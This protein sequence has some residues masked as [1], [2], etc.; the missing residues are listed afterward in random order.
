MDWGLV[1][2]VKAPPEKVGAFVAHH[3]ALGCARIWLYFDDPEDPA[4]DALARIPQVTTVRC[5]DIRWA[6][7]GNRPDRHQNR[8]VKN[9]QAAW[10]ACRL[11]WLGHIDVDEFLHPAQ[12]IAQILASLPPDQLTLRMEPFE[13]MHDPSLPDDIFTARLFRGPLK[14]RFAHL[15]TPVLGAYA[16]ILPEG[17]LSHTNGKSFF[18]TGIPGLSPRLHGAFLNKERLPG[19]PFDRR[20]PLLHFHAQD[21]EAWLKALPFRRSRGAYQ[22]HP[23]LQAHLQTAGPEEIAFFYDRTQRLTAD[24]A[25]LLRGE[26]RLIETDLSLRHKLA[27]LAR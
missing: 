5:D 22:Y 14:P 2:T 9:A 23:E 16:P 8:Q 13:A 25:T 10:R 27:Q 6:T 3:L 18:R 12:P 24:T 26:A 21:R 19:P 7:A 1:S 11:P 4:V 15:R 17:H 20:L